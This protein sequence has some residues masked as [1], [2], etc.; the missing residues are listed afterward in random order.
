LTVE[1][2][3][4]GCLVVEEKWRVVMVTLKGVLTGVERV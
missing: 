3:A 1:G 2:A 4:M